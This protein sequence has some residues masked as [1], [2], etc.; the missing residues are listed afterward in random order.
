MRQL[1]VGLA[2]GYTAGHV[3]PM[4]AVAEAWQR[5]YPEDRVHF[6]GSGSEIET[7]LMDQLRMPLEILPAAPAFGTTRLGKLKAYGTAIRAGLAGR[8]SLRDKGVDLMISFGGYAAAGAGMA[9]ASLGIPLTVF[10]ANAIPGRTNTLLSRAARLKIVAMRE[11]T[12]HA[13]WRNASILGLPRRSGHCPRP[14]NECRHDRRPR[15]LVTGGTLGSDTLNQAVPAA[16]AHLARNA[17]V[18][19]VVHQSGLGNKETVAAAYR[20]FGIDATVFDFDLAIWDRWCWADAVL[21]TAGAGTLSDAV[22]SGVPTIAVPVVDVAD[23]HQEANAKA[24]AAHDNIAVLHE[25][26]LI[27][28]TIASRLTALLRAPRTPGPPGSDA[29]A[30]MVE[31]VRAGCVRRKITRTGLS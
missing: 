30:R 11:A 8:S 25:P 9:A 23:G 6:Y 21:C 17:N 26:E 18:V 16:I 19:D 13:R 22:A 1:I 31:A 10:E 27:S 14:E 3:M 20:R 5:S 28:E 24:I 29:A 7:L 12:S 4:I 15:L 2:G